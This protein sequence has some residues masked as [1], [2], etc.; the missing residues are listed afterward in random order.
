[1]AQPRSEKFTDTRQPLSPLLED[2][3]LPNGISGESEF[4][5]EGMT[6]GTAF[7]SDDVNK[8]SQ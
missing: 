3:D 4:T 6:S 7:V 2:L 5:D 1:M 8:L